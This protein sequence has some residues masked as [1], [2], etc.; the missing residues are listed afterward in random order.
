MPI[1]P[2]VNVLAHVRRLRIELNG[3]WTLQGFSEF[4]NSVSLVYGV[5]WYFDQ[6]NSGIIVDPIEFPDNS[7]YRQAAWLRNELSL[8]D[9]ETSPALKRIQFSSPGFADIL[10]LGTTLAQLREILKDLS[11]RNRLEKLTMEGHRRILYAEAERR[12]LRN[13]L[14]RIVTESLIKRVKRE[15][16]N[17]DTLSETL[18]LVL[19]Q[20]LAQIDSAGLQGK[21]VDIGQVSEDEGDHEQTMP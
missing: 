21:F 11:Y 17:L 20:P 14:L 5:L 3:P 15:G 2:N 10:G 18:R 16:P 6:L 12:E 1:D 4:L 13:K 19:E 8:F 9:N 7:P